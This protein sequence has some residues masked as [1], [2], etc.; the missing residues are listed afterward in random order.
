MRQP[1]RKS[2][3]VCTIGPA[4]HSYES[5]CELI[6]R[7][8]DVARLNFS[9]GTHEDHKKS[10]E[11]IRKASKDLNIEA[12]I[13]GDL[14]GPKIRTGRLMDPKTGEITRG[15]SLSEGQEFHFVGTDIGTLTPH[16]D[17]SAQK[18]ISISYARLG[19]DLRK[20]DLLLFDDG[21]VSM[22]VTASDKEKNTLKAVV[23]FGK[24]LGE[25]KGVNMPNARLS[26][27]GITEKDWDDIL[28]AV[29]ND[30][31]FLALS[32]VRSS[33]EVKSLK[34]YL[35]QKKIGTHIIAKIEKGEAVE[36]IDDILFYSDGIMVARGD[37]GVEIGNEK[38]AIVQ[39]Q[40]I[41]RARIAG[42]PVITATQML[43]SMVDN[44]SPS[45]AEASDVA[46]A[47][48]DGSDALML[49]NETAT[50]KYPFESVETMSEVIVGAETLGRAHSRAHEINVE[51][52]TKGQLLSLPEA[53]DIAAASLA[54]SLNAKAI[55]C[56]T[57]SGLSARLLAKHRPQVPIF[58]FA[59]NTKV[60][61][62]L[63]LS[64]G[65]NVVPWKEISSQDHSLFDEIFEELLRLGVIETGHSVVMTAGIPTTLQA[66]STNTVVV[67]SSINR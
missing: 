1:G 11:W 26:S 64:W 15:I 66:G 5:I 45:R 56:L 30:V 19:G 42:K 4:V 3:I 63:C 18:P 67:K 35:E 55:T 17:G 27:S 25:N 61:S 39:K 60:R 53:I 28:F 29:E 6:R 9:H 16:G 37:L 20:G 51:T 34:S 62:Q 54:D 58:A 44:P 46:N 10:I 48:L 49:S 43:M 38:V 7:G 40:L 47:V 50:G 52:S 36:A 59:E 41:A 8:M 12:A 21:L 32:F 14:Q 33:R 24:T 13:L 57:R 23:Q 2:K 22:I 31:D 65:V